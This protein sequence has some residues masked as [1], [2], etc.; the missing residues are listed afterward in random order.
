MEDLSVLGEKVA[1]SLRVA[2]Q[3][4]DN[5]EIVRAWLTNIG[6][7]PILRTDYDQNIALTVQ[8]PWKIITIENGNG[9]LGDVN[10]PPRPLVEFK[11][12]RRSDTIF[13]AEPALLNPNDQVAINIYLTNTNFGNEK[14]NYSETRS[15]TAP[16]AWKVRIANLSGVVIRSNT[17]A[18]PAATIFIYLKNWGLLFTIITSMLFMALYL[19]I[20]RLQGVV[21]TLRTKDIFLIVGASFLSF[22][23]AESIS[24]YL[25]NAYGPVGGSLKIVVNL[26]WIIL[27]IVF[28]IFLFIRVKPKTVK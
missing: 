14:P 19:H 8:K 5:I 15:D 1:L 10:S 21:R 28:V 25:F 7:A 23:A 22:A 11:W 9:Y 24:T 20:F 18:N 3:T 17:S 26:P 6:T 4:I 27:H 2:D 13:E 16:V 12:N